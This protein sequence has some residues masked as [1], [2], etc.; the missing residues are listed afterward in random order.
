MTDHETRHP[1]YRLDVGGVIIAL[2]CPQPGLAEGLA[3]WFGLPSAPGGPAA[4][5]TLEVTVTAHHDKPS[6]PRSLLT[7]KRLQPG[8]GFDIADG[9]VTGHFDASSGHGAVRVK[10]ALFEG[11]LTRI[12]EQVLYQAHASARRRR[13]QPAWLVHSSA[14]I[15]DGQGFLFVGPS[16]AG[17]S[18]VARLSAGRHVLGDEMS[19]VRPLAGGGWELVGTPFNGTF[20]E[21]TPGSAPLRAILLLEHA[22]RHELVGAA[23]AE[24]VAVLAGEIVPPVGLDELPDATTLS[25]MVDAATAVARDS[26]LKVLR[27]RPDPGFWHPIAAAFGLSESPLDPSP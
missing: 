1:E 24:A 6:F 22:E 15:A 11:R 10:A 16:G 17:K 19:L 26:T 25:A 3:A 21:K 4:D 5:V 20:R 12:F 8:G 18:T 23:D 13:P 9:L 14:V 7:A 27:F 2:V